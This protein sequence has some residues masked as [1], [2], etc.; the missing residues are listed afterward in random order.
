MVNFNKRLSGKKAS[1][2]VD[3]V[4]LYDTLDRA[5]DKG[6]LRPAQI[7]VLS[8]WHTN[9]QATRDAIV[10]L[11]TG[12]GKTLIGLLMLQ[13]RLNAGEGPA[14]YLCP[15]NFLIEQTR[16]QAKE[17]GIATCNADPDLPDAFLN[18]EQIL[19]TSVQKLF[20]G[21]T[22]FGLWNKSIRV[23]TLLMDDAHACSDIVREQCRIRIA[24]DEPAYDALLSLF[25]AD[26]EQ[27]GVGTYADI[28]ND[29]RDAL[30]PVPYWA[31]MAHETDVAHILSSNATRQSVKYAWPM[32][33]DMLGF[34]QA[35]VSGAAIEIE[36]YIPPLNAFGS[37]WDAGHR[38]FMSATVTDDA[39]LIKGLQL[40]PD[41]ILYPL[42]YA[43]ER[44]SGEK[45]VLLPSL[46]HG[47]LN[48]E[49]I[50]K[51]FGAPN[52]KR[53]S[54]I[55]AL[56]PSFNWTKDW[57]S[58]G[59]TVA[60][61]DTVAS[62]IDVLRDK[63][64]TN[65]VVLVNR[66]DGID[67]PDDTCRILVFDGRPYSE[68][69]ID[70]YQESCRPHSEA[71]LMRTIRT[72]EQGMGRSVRGEKDYSVVV[73]VGA[74]ITRLVRDRDSSRFLS[75]QMS[76]QIEIG[77]EIATMARQEIEDGE[78]PGNAFNG[79][80]RQC[81]GRDDGWKA[82]YAEQMDKVAPTG[83]NANLLRTY[84]AELEAERAYVLGDYATATK[85][86]QALLDSGGVA[87]DDKGWYLQEIARYQYRT[88][89]PESQRLQV[90]AH[91]D[92]RLLLKPPSGVT[93][94]RLTLVNQGR[95]ERI[96]AW[97][98]QF[99]DYTQLDVALTDV[100]SNLVFGT[101][102]DRFEQ[103][104]DELSVALGFVSERPDKEWKEGPDNLWALDA[105]HYILWECKSE[106]E[107]TRAEINKR[108][109]EQMN[110][111]SAWF[112]KHYLGASAKRIII[113]PAAV[114]ASAAAFTHEA[115]AMRDSDL[116]RLVKHVR[117]FFKAFEGLSFADLSIPHIQTLVDAHGLSVDA[118]LSDYS[119]KVKNLK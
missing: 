47:E 49:R 23:G 108:E 69:L 114:V 37:Y 100:L 24:S 5:H 12:Q 95:M 50:V 51:T 88:N 18:G 45:M 32:L 21:L 67:L 26:L 15:D 6:P 85:K 53:Q 80:V 58:Y 25:A 107:I 2:P 109:A 81:L 87:R 89:R 9:H 103:A 84:A 59:A 119:R 75:P 82:F 11:H 54:G 66:Y 94:A 27:Q 28:R 93:V 65:T 104:L 36:P 112:E 90:A 86:V 43:K 116:R 48:R 68:S 99:G 105:T 102:A 60:N 42:T 46:I 20:N 8:E 77:L 101:K 113:H 13:S 29:K 115:E 55:V 76:T 72:I 41:T 40:Q 92:N 44:W 34:C 3:P 79:L 97:V 14:V 78:K 74:D 61:K 83:A 91:K 38:I 30:L 96:A 22:R 16:G 1:K 57:Q 7:A 62:A 17:F 106:V 35:V 64:F 19:V 73:I 39:F 4:A 70:L 98:Q 10:K 31:W 118:L 63:Q 56:A 117:E 33:R 111:S 71:T 110:R 52:A